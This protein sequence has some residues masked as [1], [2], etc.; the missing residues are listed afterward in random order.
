MLMESRGYLG[1]HEMSSSIP[2][3]QS[4]GSFVIWSSQRERVSR[5]S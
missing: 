5:K 3:L 1:A 2:G 4:T